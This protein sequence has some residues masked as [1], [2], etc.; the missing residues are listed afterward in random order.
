MMIT[1]SSAA[2]RR[3]KL[4]TPDEQP[5]VGP[6]P[7]LLVDHAVAHARITSVQKRKQLREGVARLFDLFLSAGIGEKRAGDHHAHHVSAAALTE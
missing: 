6:N 5:D 4:L 3:S 2:R 7:I 1:S